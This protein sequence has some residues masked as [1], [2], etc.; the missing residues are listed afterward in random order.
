MRIHMRDRGMR[1]RARVLLTGGG[2][3]GVKRA[4]ENFFSVAR[5]CSLREEE[6]EKKKREKTTR[7]PQ[8]LHPMDANFH[9]HLFI[10][11]RFLFIKRLRLYMLASSSSTR[12]SEINHHS[13]V[14]ATV[15]D[16]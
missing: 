3:G 4:S 16:A 9:R 5:T 8:S 10:H 15:N 2:G 13:E 14:W 12:S 1:T 6:Q 11:L 7:M